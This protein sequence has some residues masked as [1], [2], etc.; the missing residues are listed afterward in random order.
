M[1]TTKWILQGTGA[2]AW[3]GN[4]DQLS[5]DTKQD[6]RNMFEDCVE[7]DWSNQ[8]QKNGVEYSKTE[9][10]E[11]MWNEFDELATEIVVG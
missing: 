4:G 3:Y 6:L 8:Y 9:A 11:L 10:V 2:D 7:G 5:A 1:K